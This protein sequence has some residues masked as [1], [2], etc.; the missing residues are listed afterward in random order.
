MLTSNF[1]LIDE[2]FVGC[3]IAVQNLEDLIES[4]LFKRLHELPYLWQKLTLCIVNLCIY[5]IGIYL[6]R[7]I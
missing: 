3:C 5:L 1:D 2:K 6:P 4:N 7:D